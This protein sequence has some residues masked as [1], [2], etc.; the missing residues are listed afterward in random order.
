MRQMI[1][2]LLPS[3]ILF[4]GMCFSPIMNVLLVP[5]VMSPILV[6]EVDSTAKVPLRSLNTPVVGTVVVSPEHA[7]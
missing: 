7:A 4:C 6:P 3:P 1:A 5:S 2:S